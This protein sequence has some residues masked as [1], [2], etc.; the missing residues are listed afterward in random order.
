MNHYFEIVRRPD[1]NFSWEFVDAR[2]RL[3]ARSDHDWRSKKK[4]RKAINRLK[5]MM[6]NA[7]VVDTTNAGYPKISFT[8]TPYVLPLL[9]GEPAEHLPAAVAA[10]RRRDQLSG[11]GLMDGRGSENVG[12]GKPAEHISAGA[13]SAPAGRKRASARQ[14]SAKKVAESDTAREGPSSGTRQRT[15]KRT[16]RARKVATS[17]TADSTSRTRSPRR[18]DRRNAR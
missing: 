10:G 14:R 6:D 13:E 12:A 16:S 7:V 9:V 1:G 15:T 8:L 5:R 2:G 11:E 17:D 4:V 18:G 3:V